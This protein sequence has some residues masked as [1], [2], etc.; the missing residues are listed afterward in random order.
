ME[1]STVTRFK[2][3]CLSLMDEEATTRQPLTIVKRGKPLVQLV[4]VPSQ[5]PVTPF[6]IGSGG[7]LVRDLLSP[8]A[9]L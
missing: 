7:R 2:A 3:Q 6:G 8:D 4:P 1:W 9:G 5:R